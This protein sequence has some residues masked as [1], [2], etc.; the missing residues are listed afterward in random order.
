MALRV[1][2]SVRPGF[3]ATDASAQGTASPTTPGVTRKLLSETDSPA[4]GYVTLLMEAEIAPRVAVGR[5][6]HPGVEYAYVLE[7]GFGSP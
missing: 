1:A 6:T 5:H 4:A 7:G 2:R 3:V